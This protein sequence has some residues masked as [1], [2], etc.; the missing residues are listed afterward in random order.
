MIGASADA[1]KFGGR[2]LRAL[3]TFGCAGKL[4][5]MNPSESQVFGLKTYSKVSDISE[6]VDFAIITVPAW[7]V[8]EVVEEYLA[9]GIR[10]IG[11]NCFGVYCPAGG[12]TIL[13]GG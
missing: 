11:P 8:P 4:Y 7:A 13:P 1:S 9:K 12:L 5:P 2:F 6:P 10:V 3:L